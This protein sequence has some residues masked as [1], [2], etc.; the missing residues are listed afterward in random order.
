MGNA[1]HAS[2][3]PLKWLVTLA[4]GLLALSFGSLGIFAIGVERRSQS[5]LAGV[6]DRKSYDLHSS[7]KSSFPPWLHDPYAPILP[8]PS[9]RRRPSKNSLDSA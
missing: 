8:F 1:E 3:V 5:E 4:V 2:Y 6:G 7:R 9:I